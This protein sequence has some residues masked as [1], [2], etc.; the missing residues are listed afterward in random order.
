MNHQVEL[1]SG[2]YFAIDAPDH[3][4]LTLNDIATPLSREARFNTSASE[5]YSVAEHAVLVAS[6]LR[7]L[8]APLDLQFAGLHHDDSEWLLRDIPGP[9]KPLLGQAYKELTRQVDKAVWR[10]LAWPDKEQVILW[11]TDLYGNPL[12]KAVDAWAARFEA[13][14]L[15]PSK[16]RNHV[17][18]SPSDAVP[19]LT[20]DVDVIHCDAP[21]VARNAYMDLHHD[22]VTQAFWAAVPA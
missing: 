1:T 8:G 16:G 14:T 9:V 10:A 12:L 22:L 6:K 4:A 2:K 21:P 17:D 13:E 3:R 15:T 19:I 11:T 7:R 18:T 5:F 20:D